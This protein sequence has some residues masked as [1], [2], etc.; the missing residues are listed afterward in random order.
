MF[1]SKKNLQLLLKRQHELGIKL[2]YRAGY[3]M[4]VSE[5][6]RKGFITGGYTRLEEELLDIQL[7]KR[8]EL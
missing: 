8:Q 3:L 1:I 4:R 2:G 6:N 5:E 7:R